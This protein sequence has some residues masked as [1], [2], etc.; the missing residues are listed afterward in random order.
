MIRGEEKWRTLK[1]DS[2][3]FSLMIFNAVLV[4]LLSFIDQIYIRN[5]IMMLM[6]LSLS[7]IGVYTIIR[8]KYLKEHGNPTLNIMMPI[9]VVGN[10]YAFYS[11]I[12]F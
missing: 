10:I 3:R 2:V 8:F 9:Y 12:N 1:N 6:V 11:E 4:I 7:L 5:I